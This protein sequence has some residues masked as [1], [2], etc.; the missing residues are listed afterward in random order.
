MDFYFQKE[1]M[2]ELGIAAVFLFG[3]QAQKL[4]GPASDFDFAV[5]LKDRKALY[6]YKKKKEIYDSLYDIFS[7]QIKRLCDIDIVFAQTADLQFKY[8]IIRDG[9]LLY[10]GDE[11]IVS[12]FIEN[13]IEQYADF[14]PLRRQFH[15]AILQRI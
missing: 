10:I 1:K 7:A 6:D 2:E 8:H 15:E 12:D 9:V 3:S 11:K 13:T 4:A 5:L 14:A